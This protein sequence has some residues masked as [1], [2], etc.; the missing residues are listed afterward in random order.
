MNS[1]Y[2]LEQTYRFFAEGRHEGLPGGAALHGRAA[3]RPLSTPARCTPTLQYASRKEAA[4]GFK[5]T[6]ESCDQCYVSIRA[7]T[8]RGLFRL[9]KDNLGL[10]GG[11]PGFSGSED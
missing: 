5:P 7:S 11:T 2:I 4:K 10:A 1:D 8:E 9:I 3:R 6:R